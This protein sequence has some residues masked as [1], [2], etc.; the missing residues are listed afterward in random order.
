MRPFYANWNAGLLADGKNKTFDFIYE[1]TSAIC[2]LNMASVIDNALTT[3][4]FS[5]LDTIYVTVVN[6]TCRHLGHIGINDQPSKT[7]KCAVVKKKQST[8]KETGN[9][10]STEVI[11]CKRRKPQ[12]MNKVPTIEPDKHNKKIFQLQFEC[13]DKWFNGHDPFEILH[14]LS[15]ADDKAVVPEFLRKPPVIEVSCCQNKENGVMDLNLEF[16]SDTGDSATEYVTK[17]AFKDAIP[18]KTSNEVLITAMEKLQDGEPINQGAVKKMYNSHAIAGT[19]SIFQA[20]HLNQNI[21]HV[22]SNVNIKSCSVS[23]LSLLRTDYDKKDGEDYILPPLIKQFD[24]RHGTTAV[25]IECGKES[26]KLKAEI[27]C[28]MCLHQFCDLFDV[29]EIKPNDGGGGK[30]LTI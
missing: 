25:F 7:D 8:C 15:N 4:D 27:Q 22:L 21:P 1:R 12:P 14:V 18:T 9:K 28:N 24:G 11:T 20:T 26:P 19:T 2:R 23:G 10:Q 16:F 17:Y 13:N 30:I 29:K 5:T 6:G 3:G